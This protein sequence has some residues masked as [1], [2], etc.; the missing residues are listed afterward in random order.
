MLLNNFGDFFKTVVM[1]ACINNFAIGS[2][3]RKFIQSYFSL[4]FITI[5]YKMDFNKADF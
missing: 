5:V 3:S 2:M 1:S 4:I